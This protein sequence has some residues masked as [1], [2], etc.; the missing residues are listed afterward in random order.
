M[1]IGKADAAMD[2][3]QA[4]GFRGFPSELWG[5]FSGRKEKLR[6]S[7]ATRNLERNRRPSVGKT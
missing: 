5:L 1:Q 2:L 3:A 7:S 4:S 6:C